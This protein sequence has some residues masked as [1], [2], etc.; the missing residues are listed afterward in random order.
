MKLSGLGL[1]QME[2]HKSY[3]CWHG[4]Q[5]TQRQTLTG[6]ALVSILY[7]TG[8]SDPGGHRTG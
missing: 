6:Q 3:E 5:A 7:L 1:Q 8:F 4:P 2:D